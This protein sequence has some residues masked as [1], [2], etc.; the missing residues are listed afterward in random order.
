MKKFSY[1]SWAGGP[2]GQIDAATIE[3]ELGAERIG[4]GISKV[5]GQLS[6]E[7]LYPS[8]SLTDMLV[9]EVPIEQAKFL[10]LTLPS[11]VFG[12]TLPSSVFGNSENKELK[13]KI[14]VSDIVTKQS[15]DREK[16]A[17]QAEQAADRRKL[18][19]QIKNQAIADKGNEAA[20]GWTWTDTKGK[21]VKAQ[22][23]GI[24]FGK[25]KLIAEERRILLK[26]SL[27]DL[28]KDEQDWIKQKP[29]LKAKGDVP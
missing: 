8:K 7:S 10:H 4:F 25:V 11:S 21:K 16:E 18:E 5:V 6:N 22:Y 3:D 14:P 12:N 13:I 24:S 19:E 2:F 27:A 9:F 20:L 29:W 23:N 17:E 1:R 15:L 28:P 26:W